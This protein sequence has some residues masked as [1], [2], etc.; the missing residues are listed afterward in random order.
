M[1]TIPFFGKVTINDIP[2]MVDPNSIRLKQGLP[3][4]I[5]NSLVNGSQV[6]VTSFPDYST[7]R[8]TCEFSI[9]INANSDNTNP[10]NL[11]NSLKLATDTKITLM[12]EQ[13]SGGYLFRNMVLINDIETTLSPESSITFTFEGQPA[14]KL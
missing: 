9:R 4:Y 2:V 12:P 6:Q 3:N 10:I 11:F 13:G 1:T 5:Q 8:S 7:A 14:V